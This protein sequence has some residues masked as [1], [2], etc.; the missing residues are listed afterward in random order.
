[1]ACPKS[2]AARAF[3]FDR[4]VHRIAAQPFSFGGGNFSSRTPARLLRSLASKA[5]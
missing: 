2:R 5:R 1:M 4:R 3:P